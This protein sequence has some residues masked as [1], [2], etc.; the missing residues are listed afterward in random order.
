[1]V[2]PLMRMSTFTTYKS[3]GVSG[4]VLC[5]ARDGAR[6]QISAYFASSVLALA[7]RHW[8][9][10]NVKAALKTAFFFPQTTTA[11]V[12]VPC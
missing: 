1:M 4:F 9:A 2:L 3:Q 8:S 12:P 7:R 11:A 6:G 5:G 10:D